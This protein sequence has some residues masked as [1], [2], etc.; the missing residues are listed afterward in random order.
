[1]KFILVLVITGDTRLELPIDC[2]FDER[3]AQAAFERLVQT[4]SPSHSVLLVET[5][6]NE[7]SHFY[8]RTVRYEAGVGALAWLDNQYA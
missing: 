1:M 6:R 7:P 8:G 5:A 4:Y 2:A 3:T